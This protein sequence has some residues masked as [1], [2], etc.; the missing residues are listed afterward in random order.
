MTLDMTR[1]LDVKFACH[2]MKANRGMT[3]RGCNVAEN[4]SE[5][6]FSDAPWR[7]GAAYLVTFIAVFRYVRHHHPEGAA[8]YVCTALPCI[9]LCGAIVSVG[10]YFREE[11]DGYSRELAMRTMLWGAGAAMA[12]NFFLMFLRMFGWRGQ[13]LPFLE[14]SRRVYRGGGL[15]ARIAYAIANRPECPPKEHKQ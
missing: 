11:R 4:G 9:V 6:A 8:L 2:R 5:E 14:I 12:T 15:A 13:G 10:L 7:P 1:M 3:K